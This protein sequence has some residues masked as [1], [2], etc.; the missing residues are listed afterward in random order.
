[1]GPI[2]LD[3]TTTH[4]NLIPQWYNRLLLDTFEHQ[5]RFYNFGQ[6]D[7][8]AENNGKTVTWNRF[9]P[10]AEG[11]VLTE[12]VSPSNQALATTKVS[13][14]I[15]QFGQI[16]A[17]TDLVDMTTINDMGQSAIER[18]GFSAAR[19]LDSVIQQEIITHTAPGSV[20]QYIKQSAQQ[21]YSTALSA[22]KHVS[23][24]SY[25]AVSDIRTVS[26]RLRTY[27]VPPIQGTDYVAITSPAVVEKIESDTAWA[28][29][30]QYVEKGIDNI[31]DG[32][33]GRI[34]GTRFFTSN[35]IRV[36]AG[37]N[38]GVLADAPSAGREEAVV[39]ATFLFGKGFYGVTEL[40]GGIKYYS[41][42]GSTKSDL[43]N[44]QSLFGWKA[45]FIAKVLNVSA[46]VVLWTGVDTTALG[47]LTSAR[48]A[49]GLNSYYPTTST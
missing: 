34:F 17:F 8:L 39:H 16:V 46:G 28:N 13:A 21:Y 33:V 31:Y 9:D 11:Y 29:Y 20:V 43:L 37:S 38:N 49:A 44:Q 18:L 27:D 22:N 10:L 3:S 36:S 41:A 48:Q 14:L 40:G 12:G 6:K 47:C 24:A 1:M 23:G 25:M 19:T 26:F 35:N 45:N 4:A 5:T 30:H 42:T 2:T 7:I 32:E 15:R